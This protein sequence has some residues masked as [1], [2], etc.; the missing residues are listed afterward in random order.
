MGPQ[1]GLVLN[2]HE[3]II[4]INDSLVFWCIY[5]LLCVNVKLKPGISYTNSYF[6]SSAV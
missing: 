2:C 6:I 5:A 4:W 3:A 1:N